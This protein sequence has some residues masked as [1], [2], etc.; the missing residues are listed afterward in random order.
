VDVVVQLRQECYRYRRLL[1]PDEPVEWKEDLYFCQVRKARGLPMQRRPCCYEFV[2]DEGIKFFP[3]Y[4]AQGFVSLFHENRPQLEVIQNLRTVDVPSLYP[5]VVVQEYTR[6]A[7]QRMFSVQRYQKRVPPHHPLLLCHVDEYWIEVLK[8][9]DML[10]P[11]PEAELRLFSLQPT[12]E[13][14]PVI[15]ELAEAKEKSYR[16]EDGNYLA[17][18]QMGNV[19]LLIYRKDLLR[20]VEHPNPPETWEELEQICAKLKAKNL[21]HRLLFET[22]TYDTLMI[23]GLEMGWSHGAF[24]SA[25]KVADAERLGR[26][27]VRFAPGSRFDDLVA[28]VERLHGW[29]HDLHLVPLACSV[30]PVVMPTDDWAFAR[31]WYSTWVDVRTRRDAAGD[32]LLVGFGEAAEFGVAKIPISESYRARQARAPG[33]PA[34]HHSASG[35]WY[36]AIHRAS[37]N[38]ELGIDLI[39][40]LMTSRKVSERALSGAELPVLEQFYKNQGGALCPHTDK[41][42]TEVREMFAADA[43]SRTEFAD[44]RVLGRVLHGALQVVVTNPRADVRGLLRSALQEIDPEFRA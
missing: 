13:Q 12:P 35:E 34:R 4:A 22:Q 3:T 16:D 26:L 21:P 32:K 10:Y 37:E 40:N 8:Q 23:A 30:D 28:A 9:A 36:L 11:I 19:G 25:E 38:V 5:G 41:T 18:P 1:S 6:S 14:S 27:R 44:Y 2:Q 33:G 7:L 20:A 15:H 31:H 17:V 42:F 39:N 43:R 29:I 24:W